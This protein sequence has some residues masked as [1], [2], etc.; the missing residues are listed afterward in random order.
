MQYKTLQCIC[1]VS[2]THVTCMRFSAVQWQGQKCRLTL[3]YETGF[4][5]TAAQQQQ[6][7]DSKE[8]P[9][10][11]WSYPYEKLRMSAD[12][13]SR[14]IWLDFGD[15]GEQV[16]FSTSYVQNIYCSLCCVLCFKI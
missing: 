15:C 13:G 2:R 16:G 10:M 7:A 12:D 8:K 1:I 5:L 9:Q 14:L 11:I 4:T 6:A 3:H